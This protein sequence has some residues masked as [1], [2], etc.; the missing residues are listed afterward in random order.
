MAKEAN[1]SLKELTLVFF[2]S[3]RPA[4]ANLWKTPH[5]W[6]ICFLGILEKI[7]MSSR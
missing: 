7:I 4:F 6:V 1:V 2:L 3:L 5:R